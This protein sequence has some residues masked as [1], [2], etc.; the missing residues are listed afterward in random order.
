MNSSTDT[1][2]WKWM[3]VSDR[4]VDRTYEDRMIKWMPN[5]HVWHVTVRI[6]GEPASVESPPAWAFTLHGLPNHKHEL[7]MGIRSSVWRHKSRRSIAAT[8]FFLIVT[9]STSLQ[10][11]S[12]GRRRNGVSTSTSSG[13]GVVCHSAELLKLST[14][15]WIDSRPSVST[16]KVTIRTSSYEPDYLLPNSYWTFAV[17]TELL[18]CMDIAELVTV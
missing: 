6:Y 10:P 15:S 7:H 1:S 18:L 11:N 14:H 2:G 17:L 12:I 13:F 3:E 9:K 5:R 16:S 4:N 8:S